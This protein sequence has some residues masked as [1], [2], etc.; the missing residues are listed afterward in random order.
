MEGSNYTDNDPSAATEAPQVSSQHYQEL[1]FGRGSYSPSSSA[2]SSPRVAAYVDHKLFESPA[3]HR[4]QG[5]SAAA[6]AAA[7]TTSAEPALKSPTFCASTTAPNT[8]EDPD[9]YPFFQRPTAR[10]GEAKSTPRP[11]PP[12]VSSSPGVPAPSSSPTSSLL[13]APA[14]TAVVHVRKTV[15]CKF[16]GCSRNAKYG[17][18][19]ETPIA[20]QAH[21]RAGQFITNS[22]GELLR[23]TRDGAAFR[24]PPASKMSPPPAPTGATGSTRQ[25]SSDR[26]EKPSSGRK[27]A[28]FSCPPQQGLKRKNR[29]RL[30]GVDDEERSTSQNRPCLFPGCDAQPLYGLAKAV[31]P[32]YCSSHQKGPMVLLVPVLRDNG[33]ASQG[34]ATAV[35]RKDSA[36]KSRN[37]PPTAVAAAAA[38]VAAA[39]ATVAAAPE[40][41]KQESRAPPTTACKNA[42]KKARREPKDGDDSGDGGGGEQH[43]NKKG[44]GNSTQQNRGDSSVAHKAADLTATP[45]YTRG[46]GSTPDIEVVSPRTSANNSTRMGET[47]GMAPS[48]EILLLRQVREAAK[49]EAEASGG[50]RRARAPSRRALEAAGRMTDTGAQW[51]T[52]EK[53][54][55]M[56]RAALELREQRKRYRA[57]GLKDGV[58]L[59]EFVAG[60]ADTT[61]VAAIGAAGSGAAGGGS[62]SKPAG[63]GRGIESTPAVAGWRK[64]S[65]AALFVPLALAV[66]EETA[67]PVLGTQRELIYWRNCSPPKMSQRDDY[68]TMS[69]FWDLMVCAFKLPFILAFH[70]LTPIRA[71]PPEGSPDGA[72]GEAINVL[73]LPAPRGEG[74]PQ[75]PSVVKIVGFAVSGSL[76]MITVVLDQLGGNGAFRESVCDAMNECVCAERTDYLPV[77]LA[78]IPFCVGG[79]LAA[80]VQ[81]RSSVFDPGDAVLLQVF[82]EAMCA[83]PVLGPLVFMM[84]VTALFYA[85]VYIA[86]GACFSEASVGMVVSLICLIPAYCALP[87]LYVLGI[88]SLCFDK[89][90]TYLS[91][92]VFRSYFVM[93]VAVTLAT[94]IETAVNREWL[95]LLT[96]GHFALELVAF[97]VVEGQA[98]QLL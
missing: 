5:G 26:G 42:A 69:S 2:S 41:I 73:R 76:P 36:S 31:H 34:N 72:K 81:W 19:N 59:E 24:T 27:T 88:G 35:A 70:V 30:A 57:A 33:G 74:D 50:R 18:M 39:P 22:H 91:A 95:L 6:L 21:K 89:A 68:T 17:E 71:D 51:M 14:P 96:G 48:A 82:M 12:L 78:T 47:T 43:T 55:E 45:N 79:A 13:A 58:V 66:A 4:A 40:G 38:T 46:D 75:K 53:R 37:K 60:T 29:P 97:F 92:P 94:A 56:A 63:G 11:S 65:P 1:C 86:A 64:V 9:P 85:S 8:D 98:A 90:R 7:W 20:C 49:R 44:R 25:R 54:E 77:Y 23:A 84:G 87:A 28:Q 32:V 61:A 67:A 52:K 10:T 62:G 3:D 93:E 16:P 15:P 80:W 83:V